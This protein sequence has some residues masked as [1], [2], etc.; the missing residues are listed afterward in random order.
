VTRRSLEGLCLSLL[1]IMATPAVAQ[2]Q[3]ARVQGTVVDAQG[4]PVPDAEVVLADPLGAVLQTS[5]TDAAGRFT[6]ANVPLGRFAIRADVRGG[7]RR[8]AYVPLAVEAALPVEVTLRLPPALAESISV[9]GRYDAASTRVSIAGESLAAVPARIRGRSLQDAVATLP[10]W[11]TEDNGLLHARGVDDGFLYMVDGVPV[12]ERLDSLNGIGPEASSLASIN[13]VTGYVP[14]EFGYKAGGVI[15]VRSVAGADRWTATG[16]LAGGGLG[17]VD[18]GVVASG[19]ISGGLG[20]RVG[21]SAQRSD[22]YLDPV[23]PDNLHNGGSAGTL[24][25]AVDSRGGQRDQVRVGWSAGRSHYDVPNTDE[26]QEAGQDQRQRTSQGYLNASWQ[27]VWS[28]R[29]VTHVAGYHRRGA[30]AL[31]GSDSD[32]PLH[33]E[34]DR[35]LVRTGA[36]AGVSYQRGSH[37]LKAGIEAQTLWLD[38]TFGFFVT[39]EEEGEEAGLSEA[40][41]EH[42]ADD[43]FAFAGDARPSLWSLYIQDTWQAGT[44][45]TI[46]AG[47]RFDRTTLL[48]PRHQWSPR[49]GVSYRIGDATVLRG[50]ASRFYQPPQPEHLLLSSSEEAREL[51]PFRT[52]ASEGGAEVEP[53]RQWAFEGGVE[54]RFRRWRLDVAAWRR[55]GREV[56][57]PNVF[58]GTTII[59]PNAVAKGRAF[60]FDVRLEMPRWRGWSGYASGTLGTVVQT[61]PVTGGLFLEDEIASIGPGVEFTPDHDQRA[62]LAGGASWEHERSG[63]TISASARYESG[64]PIQ[65]EEED[66][67]DL[68]DRPGANMVD[69]DRGRVK[70]RT[71]LSIV[72]VVPLAETARARVLLRGSVLNLFDQRYAFNFGNPFSGTHFGT[73]RTATV[74]LQVTFR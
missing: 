8:S 47:V 19:A 26:Q 29:T 3:A 55:D 27:R 14:P 6:F 22:R 24:F 70:P 68:E 36:I 32:T 21:G 12:Y 35:S 71:L 57:D 31:E 38:E 60:G 13:V 40:A 69:F 73:P 63:L 33:A 54:H 23:H 44:R 49:A 37:L 64:T 20:I 16:D 46:G 50:S 52:D 15:E 48:L 7:M 43:P 11:A 9:E 62:A 2:L 5:T 30:A 51:S 56:A 39:D 53:E 28:D 59:F 41:L 17:T 74:A 66:E 58:F 42:D 4:Q 1:A 61:G 25:G 45:L 67:G 65:R 10:G 34:S 72:A 18:G